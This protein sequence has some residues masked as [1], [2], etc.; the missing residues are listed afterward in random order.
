MRKIR[1]HVSL[2]IPV[3][4]VMACQVCLAIE[5]YDLV[6]ANGRVMDPESGLDAVRNVAVQG[7]EIA[8]ISESELHGRVILDASG[9]VIAPG[10]ID[11]HAH[12]QDN[13]A[14][15]YQARD[16]VTTALDLEAGKFPVVDYYQD[17]AGKAVLNYGVAVS[18][19]GVRRAIWGAGEQGETWAYAE[20]SEEDIARILEK[21]KQGLSE[22]G[23]GAGFGLEYTPGVGYDEVYRIFSL[24]AANLAPVTVHVRRARG[25]RVAPHSNIAAIQEVL[26][27]AAG[28]GA[29]LHIVHITP[30]ALGD[31]PTVLE[32]ITGARKA[33]VNVSTEVYPY[34]AGST[35]IL[36]AAFDDGWQERLDMTYENLVWVATGER[37]TRETFDRYRSQKTATGSVGV[38]AHFI[39]EEAM[40]HA[41]AHPLTHIAS[42]GLA[43]VTGS[44]HPRGA[45]T[46]ARVLGRHVRE[47]GDLDLMTAIR[48]MSY[49]PA[50]RLEVF[51]PAMKSKGRIKPGAD[52]DITIFDPARVIDRATYD[53]PMQYSEGIVHVL[54]GG[55]FVVRDEQFVE[56]VFP[57]TAIRLGE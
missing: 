56:D 31:T 48:K 13:T 57:G 40:L 28:T 49:M 34:T 6:L 26:A 43:W 45:G 22:G 11:F 18:H 25:T 21:F 7:S 55:E 19:H 17:R 20:A 54:V 27:N 47:R 24:M 4:L 14:N 51:V 9:L 37:L 35:S 46:Y 33:G 53:Q 38:I 12:G 3:L 1:I 8:K 30:S 39:P 10:F 44:E 15:R 42:D 50:E 52:A 5:S 29:A 32:M 36:S 2:L 41:V 16:G 23:I